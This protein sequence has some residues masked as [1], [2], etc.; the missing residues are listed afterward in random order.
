MISTAT[1]SWRT[2]VLPRW[3]AVLGVLLAVGLISVVGTVGL[4]LLLFPVWV[5]LVSVHLLLVT[6]AARLIREG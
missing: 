2:G 5:L 3:L 4:A 1:I 6:G